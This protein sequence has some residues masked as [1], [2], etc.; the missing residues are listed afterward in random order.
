M[1]QIRSVL[2][3]A[4]AAS[5][6]HQEACN[7]CHPRFIHLSGVGCTHMGL[8]LCAAH[9][10]MGLCT[11]VCR[12]C[13]YKNNGRFQQ[14]CFD[15]CH[16]C[17]CLQCVV[18]LRHRFILLAIQVTKYSARTV[19]RLSPLPD[20]G[21]GNG[22]KLRAMHASP[23]HHGSLVTSASPIA[24]APHPPRELLPMAELSE[25]S[26]YSAHPAM[27]ETANDRDLGRLMGAV[28][29]RSVTAQVTKHEKT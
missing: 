8:I 28:K 24:S 16:T 15:Y 26:R 27:S 29:Q 3:R 20:K 4:P 7:T 22:P 25:S 12:A 19:S 14:S 6:A 23:P 9:L 17:V 1:I 13:G 11:R 10:C 18:T 5:R 2:A 21:K